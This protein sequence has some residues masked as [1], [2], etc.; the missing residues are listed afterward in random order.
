[1]KNDQGDLPSLSRLA[2]ESLSQNEAYQALPAQDKR[3]AK[4]FAIQQLKH[5]RKQ[6]QM[7]REQARLIGQSPTPKPAVTP[8]VSRQL[9]SQTARNPGSDSLPATQTSPRRKGARIS[10]SSTKK[11][12]KGQDFHQGGKK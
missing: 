12:N 2:S 1:V 10:I 5:E 3:M 9:R 6:I 8:G 4:K 11:K 7:Q